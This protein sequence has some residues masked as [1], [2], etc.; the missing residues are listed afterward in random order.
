MAVKIKRERPDQRR[1]HRVTAPLFVRVDGH[2]FRATDWSLGGLRIDG[3][4][5]ELPVAGAE[6]SFH[7]TLPFQ[8]FDV[9]FD[10]KGEVVRTNVADKMFAIRYTEIG[11]RERELMQHFIEELVRGSMSDVEDTIQRIDVPV[12]PARLEPDAKKIP[13]GIPVRRW[14][15]KTVAM[16]TFYAFAGLVVFGYAGLL[17]YSNFYR[18]EIQT[19]VISA[20]VELVTAQSDGQVV[21]TGVKPGDGVRAGEVIVKVLDSQIE[22]EIELADIAVKERKAQ[23]AYLKQK[24]TEEL[25]RLRGFAT[26]EMKNVKQSK[27]ELE[28]LQQQLKLV[29]VQHD[30]MK[31]LFEKGYMT[32][33]K[34]DEVAKQVIELKS[35][36]ERRRIEVVS[37]AD[38]AEQNFGK[39]L[40]TGQTIEGQGPDVEAQVRLAE[41][42]IS[43]AEER[44]SSYEKQRERVAAVAPFDG[45]VLSV[46]RIDGGS[47][48]RGDTLAVIEQRRDRKITAFLNQDEILKVGLGDEVL[49]Y[50]PALSETLRG[51]V[52]SIDRTSGFVREQDQRQNPGYGWRGPHDRSAQIVI[53]FADR[54]KVGDD[55]R[56]RAGLPV[57]VVFEQR[58]TNSLLTAI[59]KKFAVSL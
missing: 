38:L 2:Q 19:A 48:R 50:I 27:V 6:L 4:P 56:Y 3:F 58:S 26:V 20:P 11:E 59:K 35:L 17:G 28:G 32:A 30:R 57:V 16:T 46:P 45:T 22:R 29:Q 51:R 21:L 40:Y 55:E 15:V 9:S 54:S 8:G 1:H 41:H 23:L 36:I 7:L 5:G 52:V 10:V 13:D 14:P 31:G 42:E 44:R 37:R 34:L 43:L 24:Q 33:S 18:M 47:V 12:T 53:D 39:R 49:I 25:E